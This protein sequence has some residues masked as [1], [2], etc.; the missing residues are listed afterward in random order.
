MRICPRY[1]FEVTDL[2]KA[3]ANDLAIDGTHTLAKAHGDNDFDRAM[4]RDPTGLL[5]P[6]TLVWGS[7]LKTALNT[8]A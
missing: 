8:I 2:P 4:P 3:G 5:G 1:E 7:E 6:V